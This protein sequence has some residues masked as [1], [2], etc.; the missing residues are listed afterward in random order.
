MQRKKPEQPEKEQ[1]HLEKKIVVIGGGTGTFTV[2]SGLKHFPVE[3]TAVV[4][5]ADD[6]GST[7]VLRDEFG[8]LP[9]GDV[10][11]CL[12]A[13]SDEDFVMRKLFNHRYDR[14]GLKGHSFGNIFISTL[15]Q[16]TGSIDRAID[17]AAS[18]LKIRGRVVP[19]TL[20]KIALHAELN[21]GKILNG[22][23]AFMEYQ[24]VSKY[25]IRKIYLDPTGSA[26]PKALNA[27][28]EADLIVVGPGKLYTSIL[29][30]FLVKGVSRAFI[31]S[32]AKKIF[33]ANLMS[34]QGHTDSFSVS[35]YVKTLEQYIGKKV[36]D[37][38]LYNTKNPPEK[39][40]R[41]YAD[42]GE[43]VVCTS[44]CKKSGYELIGKDFLADG[45]AKTAKKDLLRRTL[46]R[47]DP[48]KLA[49]ILINL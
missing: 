26:N 4:T 31:R 30:N 27:I 35:D 13:L 32:K 17:V 12:V 29:P 22:E 44:D 28:E 49:K 18:I 41:R 45:V 24:L 10:R 21:N 23:S 2:L 11:Q 19:V 43:P 34:Q 39:L 36:F 3:L 40:V 48:D 47:H 7:G 1:K 25:G 42:E 37:T 15:E 20:D 38:I 14:G 6:G 5:M 8:V 16:V 33:I 9:P 46:I